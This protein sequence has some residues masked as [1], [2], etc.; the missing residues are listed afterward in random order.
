MEYANNINVGTAA[1]T[2]T[3][4]GNFE[5]TKAVTFTITA[6]NAGSF[7][8]TAI[9][10]QTYTGGELTPPFEVKFNGETLTLVSAYFC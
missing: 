1:A 9:P 7:A 5:G 6:A 10:N 8:V 2:I 4:A 3:G